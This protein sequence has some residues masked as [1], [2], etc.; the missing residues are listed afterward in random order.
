MKLKLRDEESDS[1]K[2]EGTHVDCKFKELSEDQ[3]QIPIISFRLGVIRV[4]SEAPENL[5]TLI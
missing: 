1:S 3:V 2:K 4:Q 5:M